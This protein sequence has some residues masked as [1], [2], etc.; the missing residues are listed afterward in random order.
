MRPLLFFALCAC[1]SSSSDDVRGPFTGE[2]RRFVVDRIS[3]P[4][5]SDETAA[6]AG[7][8]DGNG[9][10]E[11]KL[12]LATATLGTTNDLT[13]DA[14]DMIASGALASVVEIQADDLAN[15][16]SVGVRYLGADDSPALAAGG[17]LIDGT[18]RSNRAATTRIPG[19]A[20]IHL[21]IFTNADPLQLPLEGLEIDLTADGV[22]GF[23]AIIRGGIR[24]TDARPI[25]YVGL[26]Q[27]FET[28]PERHLVFQRQVDTNRDGSMS[29]AE[30]EESV[31][32]LLVT[33]DI[34]LF[35]G[36]RYAPKP[37]PTQKDSLSIAF[38]VH[39]TPCPAGRCSTA[40]PTNT[41]RDRI[42]DA[43]E[44][45]VDCGGPTC[46]RCWDGLACTVPTDCQSNACVANKCAPS[47]CT[48]NVRD[49]YESDVD[50]GSTCAT[51]ATGA[52]CAAD[53]DCTSSNCNN[54]AAVTGRCL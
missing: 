21:P 46:Q 20:V 23:D 26:T 11:N 14:Q 2:V 48:N 34:Q 51:C 13:R 39:L 17:T 33:A 15:D 28:E 52:V 16:D 7:D 4:S 12:G 44:T 54:G 25:S 3:V 41:C 50:C 9:V 6:F 8:L 47:T 24:Q 42:R 45:D 19:R 43:A 10:A 38:G 40:V 22:G 31:I 49:G 35:D 32:A 37:M 18:F 1:S 53:S 36:T 30:L 29:D 5:T 27:M